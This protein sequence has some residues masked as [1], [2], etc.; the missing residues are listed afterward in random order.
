MLSDA[1]SIPYT[2]WNKQPLCPHTGQAKP[3]RQNLRC[4]IR[5]HCQK[6]PILAARSAA[7]ASWSTRVN[8]NVF[9][10]RT[11]KIGHAAWLLLLIAVGV[12]AKQT[13]IVGPPGSGN[14]GVSVHALP[15]GNIVV[16]DPYY[17]ASGTLIGA[18]YLY[19]PARNLIS[20]VTGTAQGDRVG[21]GGVKVLAN[22][23]FVISSPYW[24][25]GSATRAGAVT[26][27]DAN[28]GTAGTVSTTNSLVGTTTN[29]R[30]GIGGVTAL[31]NGNYVVS[32]SWWNGF[33]GA[34]T[35]ASGSASTAGAVS[36]DNSLVGTTANDQVSFNGI[37]PLANGNYVVVS[38]SWHNGGNAS[39]GA[40]TW[41]DGTKGVH[42]EVSPNNSLVGTSTFDQIG[43]GGVTGLVNGNY[44]VRS[45]TWSNGTAGYAGAVTWGNGST[46][47]SGAVSAANSLVGTAKQDA[48]GREDITALTNGNYVVVSPGWSNASGIHVGAVTW[49][50]GA[51]GIAG[52]VTPANSLVGSSANDGVGYGAVGVS[53]YGHVT[54]LSN[55]NYV[56]ASRNWTN[57]NI[58]NAGAVTLGN[59]ST[60]TVGVVSASNS[61]VG[62]SNKDYVGTGVTALD[63]GNYVVSSPA[64]NNGGVTQVGA[65]TWAS[66]R[67][68]I[69]GP[70][71]AANSLIGSS[72]NDNVGGNM[73][74]ADTPG[75]N[76]VAALRNGNYIVTS[77]RWSDGPTTTVGAV[78]WCDGNV[79][80]TG[81][82][83]VSNSTVGTAAYE[84]VGSPVAVALTNGNYVFDSA[85][86]NYPN[87]G[88]GA[89]TWRNGTA[90]SVGTVSPENSLVGTQAGDN[91][92]SG[93][94]GV[95]FT[96][97]VA[98]ANGNYVIFSPHW[99][100][101]PIAAA[102][103]ITLAHGNAPIIG[104]VDAGNSVMGTVANA[105]SNLV[106]D[107]DATRD[108]L[109]VGRP[110]ENV[111]TLLKLDDVAG[112]TVNP[113]QHGFT[114]S[115]YNPG[116]AGQGIEIE[117]YPDLA[118]SGNGVLFGGW[119]TFDVTA[120]GGQRWYALQGTA[121]STSSTIDLDIATGYGGNLAAPPVVTGSLVG[122]ATL[123]FT[124]C[125]SGTLAY[126]FVDGSN[127][128]GSMPLR[129]LISNVTCSSAGD[130]GTNPGDYLLSGSWYDAATSGQGLI[131]D[132]NPIQ[133][134]LFAAWYT[135]AVNGQQGG[136]PASQRWYTLQSGEFA[137]G[138]TSL[139][140]IGIYTSK[141]GVFDDPTATT[142]EKVGTADIVFSSCNA[143][144]LSY[145]FT[146]PEN[147]GRTGTIHLTRTG[148]AP[149]GCNL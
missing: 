148:P 41:G 25:N 26:W 90:Q 136:G 142:T 28:G 70:V 129:R 55:G 121:R 131:F 98:L 115:W 92:G 106:Y 145:V 17:G 133:P 6:I 66:G 27:C 20:V 57:G 33:R 81:V 5:R 3:S 71:S 120:P 103:A 96:G 34:A 51:T 2:L 82:V 108:Q 80:R 114:G 78:T 111:V 118:G 68:G 21:V 93:L 56:V 112:E 49:G 23:N 116:T 43:Y 91:L 122:H 119:F 130:N 109:V 125:N 84:F 69:T 7:F 30:V 74:P 75:L 42:G 65:V 61:L 147:A 107:Y 126:T 15:N 16:A 105:G 1:P 95:T 127:R 97:I 24:N 40:V 47:I 110:D 31:K 102:G 8:I 59:G 128:I 132:I 39:A 76:G 79:G 45:F 48:V 50:N 88:P 35:W 4:C 104:V 83:S 77:P 87:A 144:T 22:G 36:I 99:N 14:F 63:N 101:G 44:V 94:N 38:V 86:L 89:V 62:T 67:T 134:Y 113:N 52:V 135:F 72:Q 64:W 146:N 149:V 54:A 138:V 9:T 139:S 143:L 10:P 58:L 124:D 32:S 60:G 100:N 117:V 141:G 13:D 85:W 140:N 53:Q 18:V 123:Q 73:N 46:G 19:G 12:S 137:N 37:T 29:D 11:L